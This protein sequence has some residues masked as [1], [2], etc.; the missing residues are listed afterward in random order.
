[1]LLWHGSKIVNFMGLLKG[2]L[3]IAPLES[4]HNGAMFG[5][6]IYLADTF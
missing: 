6:G 5:K 3:K 1:M 4:A 2:G